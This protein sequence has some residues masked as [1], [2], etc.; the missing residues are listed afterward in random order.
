[1]KRTLF[2]AAV[3]LFVLLSALANGLTR[4]HANTDAHSPY[5]EVSLT[6]TPTDYFPQVTLAWCHSPTNT[7]P[8]AVARET[9][10]PDCGPTPTGVW[11]KFPT[12]EATHT[13]EATDAYT[14]PTPTA[15]PPVPGF[16]ST[17]PASVGD[18]VDPLP[19]PLP[20]TTRPPDLVDPPVPG[21]GVKYTGYQKICMPLVFN[22]VGLS[23]VSQP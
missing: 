17:P 1:M 5:G 13:P 8:T 20:T 22:R 21:C 16:T 9:A 12:P 7:D 11:V 10:L 18:A 15:L 6:P 19:T 4:A 3:F 23:S 2:F 14:Q